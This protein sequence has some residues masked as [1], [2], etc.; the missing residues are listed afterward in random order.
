MPRSSAKIPTRLTGQK[1]ETFDWLDAIADAP[2]EVFPWTGAS[3]QTEPTRNFMLRLRDHAGQVRSFV[4]NSSPVLGH[5]GKNRGVLAS[6]EDVTELN[7]S[8]EVAE[9]ANRAKSEFL[10]RMSHEIRTPMNAIIGFADVL[11]R[12][13]AESEEESREYLETIHSSGQHL[14]D[15][16]NDIL[17]LSKIEAGKIQIELQRVSPH[18]LIHDVATVLR[19]RAKQKNIGLETSW[20]SKVPE[21]ILTDP[22]RLRQVLTNL[23][24]NAI[25]FTETGAVRLVSRVLDIDGTPK[26]QID[27]IDSGIG[28]KPESL[29]K[30]FKPFMQADTSI[31]RRFG[32]TGLGLAISKQLA[33]ALGGGVT[34]TSEYGK[35][36]TFSVLI[37]IGPLEGVR[38]LDEADVSTSSA[39]KADAVQTLPP[40]RVLSVE[41]G[42]S[43]QK[44]IS[45]VLRRAGVATVDAALNG[46]IG[47]EMATANSYD[48]IL[49]D[50]QMPVMDGYTAA[51][52]LREAGLTIPIIALTAHAMKEEE[53]KT[54]A[55]G[56]SGFVPKPIEI[57]V[58]L[59]TVAE[60]VHADTSQSTVAPGTRAVLRSGA[61]FVKKAGSTQVDGPIRSSLPMDDADFREIAD[62]FINRLG[63]QLT[64]M[65]SA[66]EHKELTKVA[67][68]AHWLKGSGGSAGFSDFTNP[69]R[70]LEQAAKHEQLDDIAAGIRELQQLASSRRPAVG[71]R[72]ES[73][74]QLRNSVMK[75]ENAAAKYEFALHPICQRRTC[76]RLPRDDR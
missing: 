25:K 65:H 26:L 66:W 60:A 41:D 21:T 6:L 19:V 22:T 54:K 2:P 71:N 12:G 49:M 72:D 30:L 8:R 17:D 5:D 74:E 70:Q 33:E 38:L 18:Q 34:V 76:A 69:A 23:T 64:E 20:D 15:L 28:M 50:M 40:I 58:L 13:F 10:A 24:G 7:K 75:I 36:S 59:R 37:D 16:I 14:L 43:N 39:A 1:V 29:D 56:C 68:L 35:G 73:V 48:I 9:A 45:L 61:V 57:D 44:L 32:G 52:K 11:R 4:V 55:A 51:R 31:T 53:E 46:Q 3:V 47:V 42:E 27:V 63:Q 67:Q 62:E